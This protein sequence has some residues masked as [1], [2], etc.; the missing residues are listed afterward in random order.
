MWHSGL[1]N[2]LEKVVGKNAV[3]HGSEQLKHYELGPDGRA[4]QFVCLPQTTTQVSEIMPLAIGAEMPVVTEIDERTGPSHPAL[5]KK[6]IYIDL[7]RMNK[8]VK[9]HAAN[10]RVVVQPAVMLGEL[11]EALEAHG[12]GIATVDAG[13]ATIIRETGFH[14]AVSGLEVVLFN[15]RI[16]KLGG[17]AEAAGYSMTELFLKSNSTLGI[18]TEITLD[19]RQLRDLAAPSIAVEEDPSESGLWSRM[20]SRLNPQRFLNPQNVLSPDVGR[21]G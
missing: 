15:G 20:Q 6:F 8:I 21:R 4:P 9:L 16:A 1:R 14:K 19:L 12:F 2:K 10:M 3:L 11:K 5:L 17:V 13:N 18:I 7:S